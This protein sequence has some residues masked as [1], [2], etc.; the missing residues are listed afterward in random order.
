M[1]TK[2]RLD[3]DTN[4]ADNSIR[5]RILKGNLLAIHAKRLRVADNSIRLRILKDV[6]V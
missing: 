1:K 3:K 6:Y 2:K 5:L 4:V